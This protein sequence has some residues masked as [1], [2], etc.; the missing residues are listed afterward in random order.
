MSPGKPRQ[1]RILFRTA[2]EFAACELFLPSFSLNLSVGGLFILTPKP[3]PSGEVLTIQF[4][5]EELHV[6][7][8]VVGHVAWTTTVPSTAGCLRH[9]PGMG[10]AFDW[11]HP[12]LR[13]VLDQYITVSAGLSTL[14]RR[15][16]DELPP[17]VRKELP[18]PQP[19]SES[20]DTV[21]YRIPPDEFLV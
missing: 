9:P 2:V 8:Q 21:Q 15:I 17:H 6:S 11:V 13:S 18:V 16:G 4:G 10:F 14:D 1:K 7:L 3:F 12:G 19:E 5:V 20:E